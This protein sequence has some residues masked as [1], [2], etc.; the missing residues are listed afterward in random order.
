VKKSPKT[1]KGK[2]M[3][4]INGSTAE[5]LRNHYLK[6]RHYR[7]TAG[8][9]TV[10]QGKTEKDVQIPDGDYVFCNHIGQPY[11][12]HTISTAWRRLAQKSGIK[13]VRLHDLR[14]TFATLLLKK[15]VNAKVVSEMLGHSTTAITMDLY[16]HVSPSMQQDAVDKLDELV[17]GS[18]DVSVDKSKTNSV[19][20]R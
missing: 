17:F 11:A 19:D 8:L 10:P 13:K 12:P 4:R 1:A 20:I 14:H 18:V 7:I 3:I 15:N 6:Q 16:S 2:R 9:L 5:V